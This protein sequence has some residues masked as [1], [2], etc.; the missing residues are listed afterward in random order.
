MC[1]GIQTPFEGHLHDFCFEELCQLWTLLGLRLRMSKSELSAIED[2][3][4]SKCNGCKALAVV[5]RCGMD[6]DASLDKLRVFVKEVKQDSAS[7]TSSQKPSIVLSI[8][9]FV[10]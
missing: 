5:K 6:N 1:R 4:S 9:T 7:L 3:V 8:S 2:E 10:E